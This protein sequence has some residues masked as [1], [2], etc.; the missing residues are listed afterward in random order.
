MS[1]STVYHHQSAAAGI[2][3]PA[4]EIY[5]SLYT[6]RKAHKPARHSLQLIFLWSG[7]MHAAMCSTF[8]TSQNKSTT[9]KQVAEVT[10]ATA[11]ITAVFDCSII[12]ARRRQYAPL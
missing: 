1:G 3:T 2:N 4:A 10:V 12:F 8:Q 7:I 9:Y 11:R 6:Y 5:L